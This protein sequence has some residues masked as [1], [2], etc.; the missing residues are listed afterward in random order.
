MY[1]RSSPQQEIE[2]IKLYNM[3]AKQKKQ[4][5]NLKLRPSEKVVV[6]PYR[7]TLKGHKYAITNHGRVIRYHTKIEDGEF[8]KH[9]HFPAGYPGVFLMVN[10][11]R[12]NAL[13]HRLVATMFLPKPSRDQ[14]FVIHIDRDPTNN[15]YK[16]L[17][18]VNKEGH[19]AH[20]MGSQRW[21]DSYRNLRTSKL[22]ES[23]VR[24]L[25][26]KMKAGKTPVKVLAKKYGV[27]DMQLY[28]IRSG[29]NW[30]WVK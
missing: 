24:E 27:S 16:N 28:R 21:I 30:G 4:T 17:K 25:K 29:E 26:K 12:T 18:W 11:K 5:P 20:A 15:N 7:R 22:T 13:V 8:I 1:G 14:V 23:K 2:T 9:F 19:L 3:T 10:G 6:L